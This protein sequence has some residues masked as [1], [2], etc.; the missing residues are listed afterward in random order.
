MKKMVLVL[1]ICMMSIPALQANPRDRCD[2]NDV[3]VT[4]MTRNMFPGA[5]LGIMAGADESNLQELV[6]IVMTSVVQS[7][8]PQRAAQIAAEISANK[9]DLVALQEATTWKFR[10]AHGW[11]VLD[12]LDLLMDSLRKTGAHYRIAVVQDLTDIQIPDLISYTDHDVILVR[13]DTPLNVLRTETNIYDASMS[14]PSMGSEIQ[15]L[16]GWI[17][18][19]VKKNGHRFKFVNTHLEAP[20]EGM[21]ETQ[22]LQVAQAAQLIEDLS[23]TKLPVI[24]AGDFNSDAE[25]TDGYPPDETASYGLLVRYGYSDAWVDTHIDDRVYDHGYSWPLFLEQTGE[26]TNPIERIDLVFLRGLEAI[27]MKRT[28]LKPAGGLYASDHAG[29]VAEIQFTR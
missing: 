29:M 21:P 13:S 14:F 17:A 20:L 15:V 12:Q 22:D 4:V 24:L 8:I 18:I 10:G 23:S 1:C 9:P 27:S 26:I 16:R 19:D 28:G 2:H 6:Q 5:D 25:P 7:R 3:S 11:V